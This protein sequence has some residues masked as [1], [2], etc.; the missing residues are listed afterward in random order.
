MTRDDFEEVEP[1]IM[2]WDVLDWIS[3]V[4]YGW[5]CLSYF[6]DTHLICHEVWTLLWSG[7]CEKRHCIRENLRWPIEEQSDE[8]VDYVY[9]LL[10]AQH[11]TTSS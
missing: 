3:K 2:I 11:E 5:E 6:Y 10:E 9:S 4:R 8:C 7:L 1:S